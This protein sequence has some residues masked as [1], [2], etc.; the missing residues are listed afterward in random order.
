MNKPSVPMLLLAAHDDKD[1]E[2]YFERAY[3]R[4]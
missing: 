1:T 2:A 4:R 3:V